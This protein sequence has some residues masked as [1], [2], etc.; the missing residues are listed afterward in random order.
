[1]KK[2]NVGILMAEYHL[3]TPLSEND[4]RQL[5][6]GDTVFLSGDVFLSRDEAHERALKYHQEGQ[7]L[8]ISIEGLAVYHCG[9]V[10]RRTNGGWDVIAAGPTTSTRMDLF[11]AEYIEKFKVRAVIGKG[12]MGD[13]TAAAMKKFGCVYLAFTGGA[14]VLAAKGIKKVKGFYWED[15][16]TP[17]G[18]WHFEID[19]FGPM[20]VGIDAKGNS[21][22]KNV[23]L[24]VQKNIAS[25]Y[26]I[27]GIRKEQHSS[28]D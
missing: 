9:P 26:E 10:V 15:L 18:M 22:Y 13:N 19:N 27:I 3:T 11:E 4:V 28:P 8:P 5:N 17:E 1:M 6:I 23:S 21:L 14:A 7:D 2:D 12:G 16:G 25:A 24:T 20:V